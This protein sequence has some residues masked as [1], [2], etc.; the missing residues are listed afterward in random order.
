VTDRTAGN[1]QDMVQ[2]TVTSSFVLLLLLLLLLVTA[3]VILGHD[4]VNA[5]DVIG[6][7]IAE[8]KFAGDG[9][10]TR[11]QYNIMQFTEEFWFNTN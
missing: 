6:D 3:A 7:V 10:A 9:S 2:S 4:D 8:V 5:S 1:L 11:G